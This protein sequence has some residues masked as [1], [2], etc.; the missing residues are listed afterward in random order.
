MH[1]ISVGFFRGLDRY[2][3]LSL[4]GL[5]LALPLLRSNY[6]VLAILGRLRAGDL[7]VRVA[8]RLGGALD[9][10]QRATDRG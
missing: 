4:D 2:L 1:P 6:T 8:L 5:S 3:S 10:A 9:D 7:G